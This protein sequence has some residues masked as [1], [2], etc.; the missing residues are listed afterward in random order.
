MLAKRVY[1]LL[2]LFSGLVFAQGPLTTGAID[3]EFDRAN[4]YVNAGDPEQAIPI[5]EKIE[6]DA[7]SIGYKQGI[8]RVGHTYAII[9]FNTSNY[10]K[11]ITLDDKYLKM[12]LEIKDYVKLCHLHRLKGCAYTELGLLD[13]GEE[14]YRQAL[15]YAEQ[16]TIAN[17]KQFALSLIYSNRAGSYIKGEANRDT[18]FSGINK[19]IA[20]AQKIT[21]EVE[22]EVSSKYSL[23]AYSYMILANEYAKSQKSRLAE[24]YYLKA[25]EIHDTKPM[26]LVEQVVLL[27]ELGFFYYKEKMYDKAVKYAE[28]GVDLERKASFPQIR[29]DLFET[30][31]KSYLELD[32]T[33]NSKKYLRL[34][35]ALNDSITSSDEKAV[36][37]ALKSTVYK[38]EKKFLDDAS[39]RTVIYLS[40]GIVLLILGASFFFYYKRKKQNQIKKIEAI[41]E[42]LKERHGDLTDVLQPTGKVATD[43]EKEEEKIFMSAEAEKNLLEKLHHFEEKK[44]FL[45]RKVSLSFVAA[46]IESNTRYLSYVIKKHKGK[47]FNKYI[48]DL[49]INYIVQKINDNPLYRQYKINVLAEEAGFSSHSKF[50]TVF[51]NTVGVSPSEFIHYFEK[52]NGAGSLEAYSQS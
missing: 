27:S 1:F 36:D 20:H 43:G 48:N 45:E 18:I 13:K 5:L 21:E 23:I 31:S 38:Q 6:K 3:K 35:S 52:N 16:I 37:T 51:K 40:S 29:R 2:V 33:E 30:L 15:K 44:L 25:L 17:K 26:V 50:G 10:K 32:K 8:T 19:S 12:A 39:R 7:E 11:A 42:K 41:L 49:R 14:E 47:D 4:L 28:R 22:A 24:A 46:E 34:F 9:Y